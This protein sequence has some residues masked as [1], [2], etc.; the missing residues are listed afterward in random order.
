MKQEDIDKN[1]L[2]DA[3]NSLPEYEP[4]AQLWN[5]IEEELEFDAKVRPAIAALPEVEFQ[6]AAWSSVAGGLEDEKGTSVIRLQSWKHILAIAASVL[7]L[8]VCGYYLRKAE[9]PK[10]RLSYSEEKAAPADTAADSNMQEQEA[11]MFIRESCSHE[12][13]KCSSEDINSLKRELK[14]LDKQDQV[15]QSAAAKYGEDEK[16]IQDKIKVENMK[17]QI[18]KELIQKLDS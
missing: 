9:A 17:A 18:I 12:P 3:I 8:L 11:E 13:V 16:I 10:V 14:D 7:L 6:E 4:D 5:R 1:K 15:L 2:Q